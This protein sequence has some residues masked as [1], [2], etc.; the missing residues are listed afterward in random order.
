MR[1]K[2]SCL[3][4]L[5][6]PVPFPLS[7]NHHHLIIKG[8]R[9][10]TLQYSIKEHLRRAHDRC[11]YPSSVV[12]SLSRPCIQEP[13]SGVSFSAMHGMHRRSQRVSMPSWLATA[14]PASRQKRDGSRSGCEYGSC[15]QL[16]ACARFRLSLWW[17]CSSS[18]GLLTASHYSSRIILHGH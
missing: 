11:Q 7:C 13:R 5:A 2:V 10:A 12:A 1:T 18:H 15:W 9:I 6:S 17:P 4:S 8:I 14:T 16:R 3:L